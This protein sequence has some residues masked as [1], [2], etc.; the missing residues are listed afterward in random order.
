MQVLLAAMLVDALHAAFEDAVVAFNRVGVDV[1]VANV[2]VCGV[3]YRAVAR[4]LLADADIMPGFVRHQMAFLGDVL[5][6]QR[7]NVGDAGAIDME[8]T[9][10]TTALYEGQD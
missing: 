9:R 10:T 2:F 5:A 7:H 3:L 4:K 6:H 1:A 8:T